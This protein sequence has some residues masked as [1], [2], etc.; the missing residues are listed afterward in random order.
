MK[1]P[2]PSGRM[3]VT[4]GMDQRVKVPVWDEEALKQ[5]VAAER[6]AILSILDEHCR[7]VDVR[8]AVEIIK[9][10]GKT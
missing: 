8:E 3:T 7:S 4:Y 6:Q 9:A 10:R 5:V 2:T 1:L